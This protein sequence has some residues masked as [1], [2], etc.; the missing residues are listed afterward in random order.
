MKIR[1]EMPKCTDICAIRNEARACL[2]REAKRQVT[3]DNWK[4]SLLR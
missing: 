4:F 2:G 3:L 1:T